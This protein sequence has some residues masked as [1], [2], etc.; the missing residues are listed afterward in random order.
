[1]CGKRFHVEEM[2][3]YVFAKHWTLQIHWM[4]EHP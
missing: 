4:N 2:H 3:V 1:M